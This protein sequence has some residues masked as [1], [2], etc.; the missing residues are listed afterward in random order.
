[1]YQNYY[2]ALFKVE[3]NLNARFAA[4]ELEFTPLPTQQS[5]VALQIMMD[6]IGL[7]SFVVAAPFFGKGRDS[8]K[9]KTKLR[10]SIVY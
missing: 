6:V 10:N 4:F 5:D 3:A 1:M 8:R 2:S 7:G 9:S